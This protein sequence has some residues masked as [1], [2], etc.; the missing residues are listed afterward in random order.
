MLFSNADSD[1]DANAEIFK[2]PFSTIL[3]VLYGKEGVCCRGENVV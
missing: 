1:A 3:S 2:W